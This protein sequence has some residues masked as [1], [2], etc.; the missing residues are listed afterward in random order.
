VCGNTADML[1]ATRYAE[2]FQVLGDQSRHFGLFDCA[3]GPQGDSAKT[4]GA[5]C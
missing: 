5:C 1:A 2:H 3:S 4:D